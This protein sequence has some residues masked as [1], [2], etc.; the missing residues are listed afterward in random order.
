MPDRPPPAARETARARLRDLL[1]AGPATAR[2]LSEAA[3]LREKDVVDHLEHLE[4]SARGR[5][6]KLVL[7]PASC[8]ACDFVF[9]D[10]KRLAKP[11]KC[12]S[13]GST[14]I[15]PPRYRLIR[16]T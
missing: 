2:E 11:G 14:R 16:K 4:R 9:E 13:C 3:S 15:D 5:G 6:E 7:E 8:I 12:P 10:R 1:L